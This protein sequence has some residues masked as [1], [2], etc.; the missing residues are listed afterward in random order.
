MPEIELI[1]I[2]TPVATD[3]RAQARVAY[4]RVFDAYHD[5]SINARQRRLISNRIYKI[6]KIRAKDVISTNRM[7]GLQ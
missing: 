3:E 7:R 2:V 1:E 5:N 6:T 4:E